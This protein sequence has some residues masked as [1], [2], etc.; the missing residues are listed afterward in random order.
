M[1]CRSPARCWHAL[2]KRSLQRAK[3][4]RHRPHP[5][6]NQV[7]V[8]IQPKKARFYAKAAKRFAHLRKHITPRRIK[9]LVYQERRMS[10]LLRSHN[11][12]KRI[13]YIL[14]FVASCPWPEGPEH[15]YVQLYLDSSW[16]SGYQ[17]TPVQRQSGLGSDREKHYGFD[18]ISAERV[19]HTE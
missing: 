13:F 6:H 18:G 3:F 10:K 14:S 15:N 11:V 2:R 4:P 8:A 1:T 5:V 7:P 19:S 17:I 9:E 12:L 16:Y